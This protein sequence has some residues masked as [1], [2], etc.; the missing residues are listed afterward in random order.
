MGTLGRQFHLVLRQ[1]FS[2]SNTMVY[3]DV[4]LSTNVLF[5]VPEAK[6]IQHLKSTWYSSAVGCEALGPS[7]I[8]EVSVFGFNSLTV[9]ASLPLHRYVPGIGPS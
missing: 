9:L 5:L 2:N 6:A 4:F 7:S 8:P 1:L 3:H